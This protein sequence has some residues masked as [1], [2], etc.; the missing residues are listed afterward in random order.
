[1]FICAGTKG[2]KIDSQFQ[3]RFQRKICHVIFGKK[4][5]FEEID[6]F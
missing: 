3:N 1:M 6:D 4:W 2:N 5:S